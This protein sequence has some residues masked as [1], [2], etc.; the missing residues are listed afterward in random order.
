MG[1]VEGGAAFRGNEPKNGCSPRVRGTH[2]ETKKKKSREHGTLS[3]RA[4][5]PP[6][7]GRTLTPALMAATTA[8]TSG[9]RAR[10]GTRSPARARPTARPSIGALLRRLADPDDTRAALAVAALVLLGEAL[11]TGLIIKRVPCA[12]GG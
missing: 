11:L 3:R 8:H 9:R 5:H 4:E 6:P 12:L 2:S 10:A 1:D 7:H